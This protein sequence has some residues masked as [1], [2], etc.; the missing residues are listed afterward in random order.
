MLAHALATAL[1]LTLALTPA[2]VRSYEALNAITASKPREFAEPADYQAYTTKLAD[3]LTAWRQRLAEPRGLVAM[4]KRELAERIAEWDGEVDATSARIDR[5]IQAHAAGLGTLERNVRRERDELLEVAMPQRDAAIRSADQAGD[6]AREAYNAA[7]RAGDLAGGLTAENWASRGASIK[8]A[9]DE[10]ER[11]ANLA[12]SEADD[13][14]RQARA[15]ASDA[16]LGR[17]ARQLGDAYVALAAAEMRRDAELV[18]PRA[19]LVR[20][21]AAL[22]AKTKPWRDRVQQA[23]AALAE[24][25][26]PFDDA[27]AG[28]D[29]LGSAIGVLQ[30][31]NWKLFKGFDAHAHWEAQ[32]RRFYEP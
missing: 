21:Q 16:E 8:A 32:R 19:A 1:V 22:D 2:D 7:D 13:A 20:A 15:G 26:R 18:Q 12:A 27:Q 28:F 31:V 17:A 30:D 29:Q 4:R 10:A 3:W 24:L 5:I 11:A 23:E 9:A 14:E 25:E 6:R